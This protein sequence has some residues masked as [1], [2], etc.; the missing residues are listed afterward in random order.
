MLTMAEMKNLGL[1]ET[2]TRKAHD[3]VPSCTFLTLKIKD[4]ALDDVDRMETLRLGVQ[5]YSTAAR[6]NVYRVGQ[7]GIDVEAGEVYITN[8]YWVADSGSETI[9]SCFNEYVTKIVPNADMLD[10]IIVTFDGEGIEFWNRTAGPWNPIERFE[11]LP[12]VNDPS[13]DEG[14]DISCTPI[15]VPELMELGLPQR[16]AEA[17]VEALKRATAEN[18]NRNDEHLLFTTAV[19]YLF[20]IKK[21]IL[22]DEHQKKEFTMAIREYGSVAKSG[23]KVG[24]TV[25]EYGISLEREELYFMEYF[26][27]TIAMDAHIAKCYRLFKTSILDRY[28]EPQGKAHKVVITTPKETID[29]CKNW[30]TSF[31]PSENIVVAEAI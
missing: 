29:F 20:K 16:Q 23:N 8:Y 26:D 9:A 22:D 30:V 19:N 28:V 13:I 6:G 15:A 18:T 21:G 24:F 10:M 12:A 25:G 5:N 14:G 11:V 3:V 2:Q 1:I 27:S 31:V 7:L 17:S 4:D